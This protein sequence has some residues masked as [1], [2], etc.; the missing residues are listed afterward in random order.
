MPVMH[1][2]L[3]ALKPQGLEQVLRGMGQ[4]FPTQS[5]SVR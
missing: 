1:V 2:N 4:G 3:L 5:A